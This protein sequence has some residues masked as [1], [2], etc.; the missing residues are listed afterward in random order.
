MT[1]A[2]LVCK[3]WRAR[4]NAPHP[5]STISSSGRGL[6][7]LALGLR[8]C[9]VC[10]HLADICDV[11]DPVRLLRLHPVRDGCHVS[12]SVAVTAVTLLYHQGLLVPLPNL[13]ARQQAI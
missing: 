2:E 6:N 12:R 1:W 8:S 4:S 10:A 7:Q 9:N 3:Y 5:A 11:D 13:K